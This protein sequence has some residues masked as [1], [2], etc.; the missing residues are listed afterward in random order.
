M[1]T[2]L[3][4]YH[5]LLDDHGPQNWWPGDS[6][7]EIMV[8]AVLTQNT[9]WPNVEKAIGNLKQA[10]ALSPQAIVASDP[11]QLATLLKPSGYFNIK[12][13]R[14]LAMCTWLQEQG[15]E[16][17]LAKRETP[18]LREQLLTVHGIGPET[19]DDILLYAFDRPVFVIDTYTRRM[20]GRL[21][22]VDANAPYEKLRSQFELSLAPEP[23][24]FNEYHALIVNHGK[25]ICRPQARCDQCCLKQQ[26]MTAA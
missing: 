8:G 16:S 10:Q 23:A 18:V 22:L 25:H 21:G 15:G 1:L 11:E 2:L 7:F 19:A 9:A 6:R 5:S 3:D 26:C 13:R 20:F 24:L 12:A 4:V 14:L 17:A